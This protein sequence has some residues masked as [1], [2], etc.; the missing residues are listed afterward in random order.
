METKICTKCNEEKFL[1]EFNKNKNNQDGLQFWCRECVKHQCK[2]YISNPEIRKN[3]NQQAKKWYWDNKEKF[4]QYSKKYHQENKEK[5]K[6]YNKNKN[7][8][9]EVKKTRVKYNNKWIKE[10]R[11]NDQEFRLMKNLRDRIY[12]YVK[13]HKYIKNNPTIEEL[14]CNM[15]FYIKYIESQF[16][17][18]MSWDNYG[19]YWEIDHKYP[20]S[21]GG[22]FHYTNTRPLSISENR[23]KNDLIYEEFDDPKFKI[24]NL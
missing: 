13:N 10:K 19:S 9:P 22:S 24:P 6:E 18:I 8:L 7:Q 16:D 17:N 5:I 11:E 14:G 21:K 2:V 20:L 23:S 15:K 12:N 3:K 4:K 1:T